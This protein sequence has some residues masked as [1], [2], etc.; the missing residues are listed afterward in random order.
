MTQVFP[1]TL[2]GMV[3]GVV[4]TVRG[5][6]K[7]LDVGQEV[8]ASVPADAAPS[9]TQRRRKKDAVLGTGDDLNTSSAAVS[10]A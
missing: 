3:D 7:K 6:G 9:Q 5:G 4:D 10:G 8:I 2:G 1:G